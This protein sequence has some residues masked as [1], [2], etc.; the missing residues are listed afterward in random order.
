[1][2]S[3]KDLLEELS[4]YLD[5]ELTPEQRVELEEHLAECRPCKVVADTSRSTVKI[6]TGCRS[7]ELP[8]KMSARIMAKIRS[9]GCGDKPPGGDET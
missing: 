4:E 8:P 2:I 3:C 5:E 9:A 7:F 6:V 1:V